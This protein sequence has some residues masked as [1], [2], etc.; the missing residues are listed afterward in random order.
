MDLE[1]INEATKDLPPAG[2]L[3]LYTIFNA[4]ECADFRQKCDQTF[5][6]AIYKTFNTSEEHFHD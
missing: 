4:K 3:E 6:N 1:I 2:S 5:A